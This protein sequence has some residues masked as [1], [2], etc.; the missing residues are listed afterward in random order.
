MTLPGQLAL[1]GPQMVHLFRWDTGA[2]AVPSLGN[3]VGEKYRLGASVCV[4]C[5]ALESFV[6]DWADCGSCPGRVEPVPPWAVLGAA[7]EPLELWQE[8]A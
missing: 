4:M 3:R 5:A 6:T 2:V 8:A 7:E 1:F